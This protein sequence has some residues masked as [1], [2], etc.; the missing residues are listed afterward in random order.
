MPKALSGILFIDKDKYCTTFDIIRKIKKYTGKKAKIG[1]TGTLD[2]IATGMVV[3]LMG[4]A[5]KMANIFHCFEKTYNARFQFGLKTSTD[6]VQ[7]EIIDSFSEKITLDEHKLKEILKNF[8]GS[9]ETIPPAYCAKKINGK[10]AY[11]YARKNIDIELKKTKSFIYESKFL[12]F[13]KEM[14]DFSFK[15]SKGTYIRSIARD[16]G[17][18]TGYGCIMKELRRM[19]I[20]RFDINDALKQ[21]E[22]DQ[23]SI[24]EN[25]K[26]INEVLYPYCTDIVDYKDADDFLN[27]AVS[28]FSKA[29]PED[30]GLNNEN[31]K[32]FII[33]DRF[34]EVLMVVQKDQSGTIKTL[35]KNNE[36]LE[37]V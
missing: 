7:G 22:I 21:A 13:E 25:L 29:M 19:S 36:R 35:Y 30:Y 34:K 6:D 27:Q 15:V 11:Y 3:I 10:P 18:I 9:Y 5:T 12:G 32:Y 31:N 17:E 14:A 16:M 28:S 1:H 8:K 33:G 23:K 2:P 24:I 26:P 20:G 37:A 4:K